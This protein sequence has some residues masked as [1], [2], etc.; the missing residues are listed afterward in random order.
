MTEFVLRQA[1][2]LTEEQLTQAAHLLAEEIPHGWETVAAADAELQELIKDDVFLCFALIDSRVVGF[3]GMI[4][5]YGRLTYELHPLVVKK[6]F[7]NHGIGRAILFALED[8]VY[9]AGGRNVYLG[10]DDEFPDRQTSLR[11]VDLYDHFLE[12]LRTFQAG[13]HPSGFYLKCGYHLVGV[14]PDA[15]GIGK[16]DILMAKRLKKR[17]HA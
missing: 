15:N 11:G 12:H 17:D 1:S 9:E 4:P 14:I 8:R 3:G 2:D 16:P 13:E 10:S 7:W 6:A 5:Q